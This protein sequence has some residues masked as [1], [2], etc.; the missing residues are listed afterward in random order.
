MDP[1]EVDLIKD[2]LVT[3]FEPNEIMKFVRE[4]DFRS[5]RFPNGLELYVRGC[6]FKYDIVANHPSEIPATYLL[7][8]RELGI[9]NMFVDFALARQILSRHHVEKVKNG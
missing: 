9:S 6:G 8:L 7:T 5:I 3:L 2:M 1:F 4:S